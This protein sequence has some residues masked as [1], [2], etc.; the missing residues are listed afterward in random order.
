MTALSV[1]RLHARKFVVERWL[2]SFGYARPSQKALRTSRMPQD[3][4][5]NLRRDVHSETK[6]NL[7]VEEGL[8]EVGDDVFDVFD[9]DGQAN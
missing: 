7:H 6:F 3:D 9:A 4:T 5:A 1:Q 8:I 2:R